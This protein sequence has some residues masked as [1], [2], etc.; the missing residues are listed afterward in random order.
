MNQLHG[1]IIELKMDSKSVVQVLTFPPLKAVAR[2][3]GLKLK[4]DLNLPLIH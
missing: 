1:I 3:A 4:E 2:I